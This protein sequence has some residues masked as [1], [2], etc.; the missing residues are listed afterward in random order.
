VTDKSQHPAPGAPADKALVYVVRPSLSGSRIQT[1]LAVDGTW[2]GANYGNNYFFVT[3]TPGEH[4]F[5]SQAADRSVVTMNVEAG[6]IYYLQQT[7]TTGMTKAKSSLDIVVE[8]DGRENV[9][10]TNFSVR[11]EPPRK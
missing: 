3:L 11:R 7:V 4:L 2:M 9:A 8:Q 1:K 6:K 5:C 10:K